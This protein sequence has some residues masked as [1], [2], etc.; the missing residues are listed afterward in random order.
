MTFDWA[1]IVGNWKFLI[2][3]GLMGIGAFGGGTLRLAIPAIVLGFCLGVLIGLARLAQRSWIRYPA[4]LYVEFFRGVPLVMVIFW[5]WFLIPQITGQ[6]LPEYTVALSAFVVFEA[7]YLAEIV[8]A[9]IQS[10]PRGQIDAA[11]SS[12]L[13]YLQMMR[14]V[15]LPQAIRNMI[16][17]LVTQFIVLFKDTSLASIIGMMDLTKAAQ[18]ISQREIRPFELYLFIAVVYWICTY[19]M[20]HISR[21]LELRLAVPH[22][23]DL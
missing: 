19:S 10:V 9:G 23:T 18:I 1:V 17:S 15:I 16:P 3:Q 4:V 8:R 5:F 13:S 22:G 20:S 21:R 12:G 2:L 7:A 14:H 6:R 11:V